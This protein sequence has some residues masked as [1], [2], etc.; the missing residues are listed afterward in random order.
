M[1]RNKKENMANSQSTETAL[2]E[3]QTLGLLIIEPFKK[4]LPN[5]LTEFSQNKQ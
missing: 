3:A 1:Q 5:I 2:E 4:K